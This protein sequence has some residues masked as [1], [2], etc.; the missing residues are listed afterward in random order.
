MNFIKQKIQKGFTLIETLVA[1]SLLMLAVVA[2]MSLAAQSLTAAYYARNQVTAFYLAQEGIEIV[3]AVRDANIIAIA[4]GN[5]SVHV[6]DG[7]PYGDTAATAP[8]FTVDS[9]Q[10]TSNSLDTCAKIGSNYA[11]PP[12]QTNGTV[13]AYWTGCEPT[14]GSAW[15]TTDCGSSNGWADT[16]FTRAVKAYLWGASN[17]NELRVSVTISWREGSFQTKTFTIN[18]DLYQWVSG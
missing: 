2:P 10:I 12:L 11:C 1:I 13:Y 5:S 15:V 3:R 18:E 17:P 7:I 16:V 14:G 4:E 8:S 6:F 9:T